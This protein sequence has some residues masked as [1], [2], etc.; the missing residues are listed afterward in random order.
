MLDDDV[1]ARFE[2]ALERLRAAGARVNEAEIRHAEQSRPIYLHIVLA[3]AAAY[4]ATTLE[5]MPDALHAAGSRS[6]WRWDGTCWPRTTC[7]RSTDAS[8]SRREVDAALADHDALVLP[9]LPIPAPP[10]GADDVQVGST[11]RTGPQR[12]AAADAAVQPHRPSGDFAAVRP[13]A[14]RACRAACSSSARGTTPAACCARRSDA[15]R[16]W[17]GPERVSW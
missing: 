12:D 9:T 17:Q 14:G 7:A 5:T 10:I 6:G 1:R 16:L 3:D 4:H 11:R 8:C 2:E 15:R 13:D